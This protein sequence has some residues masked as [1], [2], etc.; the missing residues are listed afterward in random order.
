MINFLGIKTIRRPKKIL[1]ARFAITNASLKDLSKIIKESEDFPYE[2]YLRK[3]FK[4]MPTDSYLYLEI[5]LAN[6]IMRFNLYAGPV[7][8]QI[9]NTQNMNNYDMSTK[10]IPNSHVCSSDDS[11]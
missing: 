11:K 9:T 7:R 10:N 4:N 8:M 1:K 2:G 5:H 6:F 3:G